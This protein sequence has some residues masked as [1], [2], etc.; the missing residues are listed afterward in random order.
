MQECSFILQIYGMPHTFYYLRSAV[1]EAG[2]L[3]E[4]ETS[5]QAL[6]NGDY[7]QKNI[8]KLQGHDVYSF[9]LGKAARLLFTTTH[10]N[11]KDYLLVLDYLPT[12]DYHKSRFLRSGVLRNYIS[13]H[14]KAPESVDADELMFSQVSADAF[15]ARIEPVVAN[16]SEGQGLALDY[17]QDKLIV[18]ND[19]QEAAVN[20]KLPGVISG[21]AG[22]GKSCVALSLIVAYLGSQ[23]T[24][25]RLL[26]VSQSSRLVDT[27]QSAFNQLPMSLDTENAIDFLSYD[28]LLVSLSLTGS[29]P[30]ESFSQWH[31]SYLQRLK[32]Q[33]KVSKGTRSLAEWC[34]DSHKVYEEFRI[35]SGYFEDA[36]YSLGK[37]QSLFDKEL[38]PAIYKAYLDYLSH[39]PVVEPAFRAM[40]AGFIYD[41]VI[42]DEAQDLSHLQLKNVYALAKQANIVYCMDSH[43]QLYD[44]RSIRPYL[45]DMLGVD[46]THH[47]SLNSMYRCP[48]KVVSVANHVLAF[49]NRLMGGLADKYEVTQIESIG[50]EA[51]LG[52]VYVVDPTLLAAAWVGAEKGTNFVVVTEDAYRFEARGLF[53]TALVLT[54]EEI[55]GL[56]YEVVLV[57]RLYD[58]IDFKHV[59]TQLNQTT[60]GLLTHR[61]KAFAAHDEF[62]CAF[63]RIYTSYTRAQKALLICE[64][65]T[66]F[67]Q[68]LLCEINR[69]AEKEP[70]GDDWLAAFD[71][72]END[73]MSEVKKQVLAG[74][75]SLAKHIHSTKLGGQIDFNQ[76]KLT[77]KVEPKPIKPVENEKPVSTL[78]KPRFF[79]PIKKEPVVGLISR[80]EISV[81]RL[82]KSFNE[83]VLQISLKLYDF[84]PLLLDAYQNDAKQ[85][86]S[87][88][89]FIEI[90]PNRSHVFLK[91][92]VNDKT[93]MEKITPDFLQEV[94]K[95]Q[96]YIVAEL[97]ELGLFVHQLYK[98]QTKLPSSS[99]LIPTPVCCAAAVGDIDM[100]RV[101]NRHGANLNQAMDKQNSLTS[102]VIAVGHGY[103][104]V[105]FVLHGLGVDFM[106]KNTSGQ[107]VCLFAAVQHNK[108][109]VIKLFRKLNVA[110]PKNNE[111]VIESLFAA[112]I[113][114][115]LKTIIE[116][117][118][119]GIDVNVKNKYGDTLACIA[120]K[121]GFA[122]VINL[123]GVCKADLNAADM[124]GNTPAHFAAIMGRLDLMGVLNKFSVDFNR[125]N[126]I[127]ETPAYIAAKKGFHFIIDF[128]GEL[129]IDLNQ[130]VVVDGLK[131]TLAYVAAEAGHATVLRSLLL[132][133][134]NLNDPIPNGQTPLKIAIKNNDLEVIQLLE[135]FLLWKQLPESYYSAYKK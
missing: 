58:Q 63:N 17:Y 117:V 84:K 11:G 50:R 133:D 46:S 94:R 68:T 75:L 74:N 5:I 99:S 73:W 49:K 35:A 21:V 80:E 37:R 92:I 129:G 125:A 69:L 98:S 66:R 56:E 104:N 134:V 107:L 135:S 40:T 47:V 51:M 101:L 118:Q 34:L 71:S 1:G 42:V 100:I 72:S 85:T 14:Q 29:S 53:N 57:Y 67:N 116:L 44:S 106:Q 83:R 39:Q 38:R 130:Y 16:L 102:A 109:K 33:D 10:L 2:L 88:L 43:Q 105:I 23:H 59:A 93:I 24:P 45:L 123:L 27:I 28:A 62:S 111:E 22:S 7:T 97:E 81:Q 20:I 91:C 65:S 131:V 18:L 78:E 112:V 12:H 64:K 25:K 114:H 13:Q 127:G 41:L 3:A 90:D 4:H 70:L 124:F 110:L 36:Y 15:Q 32:Q 55:K 82:F 60:D 120:V 103:L 30:A 61:A 87:L 121:K 76:W 9:R 96:K 113:L 6:L 108:Y 52:K 19:V 89:D 79:S 115:H 122:E 31:A 48:I 132:C 126:V 77:N 119:W 86:L 128:L 26:Y 54:P 8:E 95:K